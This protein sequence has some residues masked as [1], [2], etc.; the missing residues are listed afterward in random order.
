M[1]HNQKSNM[2]SI[3]NTS[4]RS[5]RIILPM[6]ALVIMSTSCKHSEKKS[7]D[8]EN[9]VVYPASV[10]ERNNAATELVLPGEL[11]GYYETGIIA[12]VNGYVKRILVDIG[13]KV[14]QGQQLVELE[15]PELMSQLDA[16]YS[17]LRAKEAM[18][19]NSKGKYVRLKQ[20]S[21]TPGAVSPYDLDFARTTV[22]ADSLAFIASQSKYYSVK[23]LTDY[24]KIPAPFD[25]IITERAMAPGAFVGPNDKNA[26]PILKLKNESRL[27]LHVAIPEKFVSEIS[28]GKLVKFSVESD[29]G[30]VFDGKITRLAKSVSSLTRSEIIEIEIDNREGHLL[31]GMYAHAIIPISRQ[32]PTMVVPT[33]AVATNMERSFVIKATY[34]KAV[35]MDVE[36]G[37]TLGENVE[38][39]G[40]LLPGDTILNTG[41]DEIRNSSAIKIELTKK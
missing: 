28:V 33:S 3:I 39:F 1:Q 30:K 21:L 5:A 31:P 18:Y 9:Q 17:E 15:A 24:L 22:I 7:S 10:V 37:K 2:K 23:S 35:W 32:Q 11:Q 38:I 4:L 14:V 6:T 36:K 40:K 13:D 25:G 12:K 29:P 19:L 16:S 34:G 26:S 27:R 41:S 20:T 8:N